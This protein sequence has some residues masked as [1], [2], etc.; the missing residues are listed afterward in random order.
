MSWHPA[1]APAQRKHWARAFRPRPI[2]SFR[3]AHDHRRQAGKEAVRR[4]LERRHSIGASFRPMD[5]RARKARKGFPKTSLLPGR[6]E[7][8][9]K[10]VET[11][12]ALL[13]ALAF[14]PEP[15]S[16]KVSIARARQI[17]EAAAKVLR[18][19]PTSA[20]ADRD[21]LQASSATITVF[22]KVRTAD[23]RLVTVTCQVDRETSM[24]TLTPSV[25]TPSVPAPSASSLEPAP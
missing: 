15:A 23:N 21:E 1:Q 3:G 18:P 19:T 16:A 22:L 12:A 20:R 14:M 10:R 8:S 5:C 13:V 9:V 4:N 6:T 2:F 25:L 17:C 11:I 24:A 7:T